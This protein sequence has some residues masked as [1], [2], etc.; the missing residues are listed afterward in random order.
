M[1]CTAN[2]H[3]H[4]AHTFFEETTGFF[5]DAETLDTAVDVF[6]GHA[7]T[8]QGL[9]C[10][11]LLLSQFATTRLTGRRLHVHSIERDATEAEVLEQFTALWARVGR[12]VHHARIVPTSSTGVT[13]K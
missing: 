6:D 3:H 7:A 11:L 5:E 8:G 10:G 2:L 4:I 1:Q 12:L 13:Q 9:I